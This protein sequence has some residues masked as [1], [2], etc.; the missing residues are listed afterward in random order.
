MVL[1]SGLYTYMYLEPHI[2]VC[3]YTDLRV[4]VA[5]VTPGQEAVDDPHVGVM[6]RADRTLVGKF[7]PLLGGRGETAVLALNVLLQVASKL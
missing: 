4:I 3:L 1:T 6:T 2:V 7:Q 5:D